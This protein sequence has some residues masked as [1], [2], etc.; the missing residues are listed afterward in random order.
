[1]QTQYEIVNKTTEVVLAVR[2]IQFN[3]GTVDIFT[4]S[5]DAPQVTFDNALKDGN[6]TNP[7]WTIREVGTHNKP[8][9][10]AEG[11]NVIE[12]VTVNE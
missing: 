3:D 11:T 5:L 9:G 10:E 6:L 7:D 2:T 1:M 12:E 8:N 4:D